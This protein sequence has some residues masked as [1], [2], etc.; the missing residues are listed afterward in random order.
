VR[1]RHNWKI[2]TPALIAFP[3]EQAIGPVTDVAIVVRLARYTA[4]MKEIPH[5]PTR[6][7]FTLRSH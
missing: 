3:D 2:Q 4:A 5:I 6:D 1:V 7:G